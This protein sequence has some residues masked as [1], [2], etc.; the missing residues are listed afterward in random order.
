MKI[1]LNKK[2]QVRLIAILATIVL[3]STFIL[4]TVAL[5]EPTPVQE[6]TPQTGVVAGNPNDV[7]AAMPE[8][9]WTTCA[10]GVSIVWDSTKQITM[11][12]N[13]DQN[14]E[15]TG[16]YKPSLHTYEAFPECVNLDDLSNYV[17]MTCLLKRCSEVIEYNVINGE[18]RTI[19]RTG[20]IW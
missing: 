15:I 14:V 1:N 7:Y 9:W 4:A 6:A 11:P 17:N 8:A 3:L 13:N 5:N 20:D 18:R 2:S 10:D 12:S 16:A 19:W